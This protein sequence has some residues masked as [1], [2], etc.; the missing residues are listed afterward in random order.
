M[1]DIIEGAPER[2]GPGRPR[3]GTI[4]SA[5]PR[6]AVVREELTDDEGNVL[7]R[8]S[9]IDRQ[10]G[11]F[12]IPDRLKKPGWDYGFWPLS[13]LGQP[14]S[15]SDI[16]DVYQG[17]WRP[18]K[19]E[20]MPELLPP[21]DKSEFVE[22]GGQRLYKRPMKFTEEAKEEER[23]LAQQQTTERIYAA[24]RGQTNDGPG[25]DIPGVRPVPQGFEIMGEAGTYK[26]K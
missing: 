11:R 17:G 23:A 2:R 7:T 3:G 5:E 26:G 12:S 6:E 8:R 22:E 15:R 1:S 4:R 18:V 20:E 16:A 10:E 9:R 21:G 24:Q 14:V 19:A 25:L 13:I